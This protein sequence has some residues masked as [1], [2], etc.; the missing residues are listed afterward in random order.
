MSHFEQMSLWIFGAQ[1]LFMLGA[2]LVAVGAFFVA[3]GQLT[4]LVRQVEAGNQA[5]NAVSEQIKL[6]VDANRISRLESLLTMESN[7]VERRL[8]LGEAGIKLAELGAKEKAGTGAD[9]KPEFAIA[10]LR[11]N[12]AAELYLNALDRLCF[13]L[14][15]GHLDQEELRADYRNAINTT[16]KDFRE[17]LG[18]GTPHRNLIKVYESWADK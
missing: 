18:P 4:Q 15:K 7:I 3:R 10:Q 2:L 14:L 1:A 12:E 13:C 11:Y 9:L 6:A 16:V 8:E 5:V 17:K